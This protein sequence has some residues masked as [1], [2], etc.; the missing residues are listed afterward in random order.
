[1]ISRYDGAVLQSSPISDKTFQNLDCYCIRNGKFKR[2]IEVIQGPWHA[3]THMC[4]A[5]HEEDEEVRRRIAAEVQNLRDAAEAQARRSHWTAF[6]FLSF[7]GSWVG[8]V[9][10]RES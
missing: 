5:V 7:F 6:G 2:H 3:C 8:A 1:M 9:L 4:P 10:F